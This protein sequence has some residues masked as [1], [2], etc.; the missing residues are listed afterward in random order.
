MTCVVAG[1]ESGCSVD[2]VTWAGVCGDGSAGW[3]CSS[4]PPV[5][6]SNTGEGSD[7]AATFEALAAVVDGEG[8]LAPPWGGR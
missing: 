1:T 3:I 7:G 4:V 2:V 8:L 6:P 5:A